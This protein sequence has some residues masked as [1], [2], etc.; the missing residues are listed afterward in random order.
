MAWVYLITAGFFEI[1]WAYTMKQSHGFTR[2]W[3]SVFLVLSIPLCIGFL[4]L[5]LR[6]LPLGTAYSVFTGIGTIGAFAV[7]ITLLGEQAGAV[8]YF[9]AGLILSGII[10][11]KLS[12]TE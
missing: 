5:S 8:R 10:I 1:V 3:P 12:S 7:G 6:E 11:M 9:A 2:L 4:T